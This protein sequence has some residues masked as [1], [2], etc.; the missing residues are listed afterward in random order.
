MWDFV[1][2]RLRASGL[3]IA[4]L[5]ITAC[6]S[7]QGASIPR[8]TSTPVVSIPSA[9]K[10][11]TTHER[12][13]RKY[14][15]YWTILARAGRSTPDEARTLLTP[16]TADSYLD[17]LVDGV[18]QMREQKR[19]PYGQVVPHVKEVWVSGDAAKVIDCQAVSGAGMANADTHELIPGTQTGT[20]A[21]VEATLRKSGKDEWRL[22]GVTIKEEPCTLSSS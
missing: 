10:A 13:Q 4:S 8:T 2:I 5:A 3:L 15:E 12:I 18:R 11:S 16:Y 21:N 1:G 14:E 9:T 7:S 19:E 6:Q 17:H 22:T 20:T